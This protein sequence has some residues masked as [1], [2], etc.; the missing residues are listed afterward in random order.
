M[1]PLMTLI[2]SWKIKADKLILLSTWTWYIK[3]YSIWHTVVYFD[4]IGLK[5]CE[6]NKC[7]NF[8]SSGRFGALSLG[9][10]MLKGNPSWSSLRLLLILAK[11]INLGIN[12]D[13]STGKFALGDTYLFVSINNIL[14]YM[15]K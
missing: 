9:T 4:H 11:R 2:W 7:N 1:L 13:Q 15:F 10:S 12:I 8:S 6:M 14:V 5:K 3:Q